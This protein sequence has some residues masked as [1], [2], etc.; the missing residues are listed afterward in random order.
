MKTVLNSI[1]NRLKAGVFDEKIESDLKYLVSE[2]RAP[3]RQFSVHIKT[4]D[5]IRKTLIDFGFLVFDDKSPRAIMSC[6]EYK[7]DGCYIW[8]GNGNPYKPGHLYYGFVVGGGCPDSNGNVNYYVREGRL[9]LMLP[10]CLLGESKLEESIFVKYP[11]SEPRGRPVKFLVKNVP[12]TKDSK[13]LLGIQAFRV[14]KTLTR[15]DDLDPELFFPPPNVRINKKMNKTSPAWKA[16]YRNFCNRLQTTQKMTAKEAGTSAD[17]LIKRFSL[18]AVMGMMVNRQW[19]ARALTVTGY[20]VKD[21]A[22]NPPEARSRTEV[23]L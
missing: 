10:V 15:P 16:F 8:R 12:A 13:G 4:A 20:Q 23:E 1:G 17:V 19:A 9:G 3:M 11:N 5:L 22:S 14:V 2:V 6:Y 18:P 21:D 7:K